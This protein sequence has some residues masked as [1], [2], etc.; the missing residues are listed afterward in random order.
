MTDLLDQKY[1]PLWGAIVLLVMD[2][3][4]ELVQIIAIAAVGYSYWLLQNDKIE[5]P[6]KTLGK[7]RL[8][9]K[10][11]LGAILNEHVSERFKGPDVMDADTQ[12]AD[13]MQARIHATDP[14]PE[15]EPPRAPVLN[16]NEDVSYVFNPTGV[17]T[18]AILPKFK[19]IAE[20]EQNGTLPTFL[21]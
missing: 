4:S 3:E 11:N 7:P 2:S 1:L 9:K 15:I 20:E 13:Y 6:I 18:K 10:M 19:Q 21:Q 16:A 5:N 17:T 12:I 14:L 8:N